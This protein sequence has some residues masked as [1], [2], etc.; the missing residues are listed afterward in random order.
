MINHPRFSSTLCLT[1]NEPKRDI[2]RHPEFRTHPFELLS[3]NKVAHFA[4]CRRGKAEAGTTGAEP[5]G[6]GQVR[7]GGGGQLEGNGE[8]GGGTAQVKVRQGRET[9]EDGAQ[10]GQ[11]HKVVVVKM[12]PKAGKKGGN[13]GDCG[14]RNVKDRGLS[15]VV[16]D[17]WHIL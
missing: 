11:Q 13:C 10:V 15:Q 16:K 6:P 3:G 4:E 2:I 12:A 9:A 1:K 14:P 8:G 17:M 5:K 7:I